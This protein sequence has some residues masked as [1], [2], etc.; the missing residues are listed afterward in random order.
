MSDP[1]PDDEALSA[2]LDGEA[3]EVGAHIAACATCGAR[4][5]TLRRVSGAVGATVTPPTGRQREAAIA[6]AIES[7]A[8]GARSTRWMGGRVA[9]VAALAIVVVG[10]AW[11]LTRLSSDRTD[12]RATSGRVAQQ[13][14]AE[15][16]TSL[17]DLGALDDP[18]AL[19]AA[20]QP[21]AARAANFQR[22]A[23]EDSARGGASA[24]EAGTSK[25]AGPATATPRCAAAPRALTPADVRPAAVATATWQGLPAEVL[26]YAVADREGAAR[27][28]VL[29]RHDCRLLEFQSYA[30]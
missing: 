10:A 26:V 21:F 9:A 2:H 12:L 16:V 14:V 3:P 7:T 27:V 29:A 8:G 18:A 19:R 24:P 6:A 23:A 28:Y 17:G 22:R 13:T 25:A 20:V 11:G 15:E 1:H 30:P 4:L 5:A